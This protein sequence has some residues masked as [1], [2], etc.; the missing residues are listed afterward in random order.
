MRVSLCKMN[1][2]KACCTFDEEFESER[3]EPSSFF[4]LAGLKRK[5]TRHITLLT[6][7]VKLCGYYILLAYWKGS[8]P[9]QWNFLFKLETPPK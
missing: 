7:D 5:G 6:P 1:I 3:M 4:I 8:Y 2:P 9:V